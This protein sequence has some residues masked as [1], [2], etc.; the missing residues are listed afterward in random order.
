MLLKFSGGVVMIDEHDM[1]NSDLDLDVFVEKETDEPTSDDIPKEQRTLRTQAYD[2]SVSDLVRMM[3]DEDIVFSPEYQR[4]YIWDNKKASLLIESILLNI[5]IPVVY[6]SED[7]DSSWNIVDGLQRLN[8]LRR[9]CDNNYRLT[10]LEVLQELNGDRYEDL[11]Q[12]AKRVLNNGMIRI[13]LIFNDSHPEI[14][15]DIF[16]RL[17][18]GSVKLKEQELRNCLYRGS[19]NEL[20]K[21]LRNNKKFLGILG[22]KDPHKRMDDVELILRYFAFSKNYNHNEKVMTHYKGK[23]KSFLNIYMH[24]NQN[25]PNTAINELEEKFNSTIDKVFAVFGNKAFRR[26]SKSGEVDNSINRSIMDCIMVSFEN[27]PIDKLLKKKNDIIAMLKELP[28]QD[29]QFEEAIVIGTSDKKRV[30][31]RLSVWN[32]KLSEIL[33]NV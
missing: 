17:N 28:A 3:R 2:K 16:M 15:Y 1:Q 26:I 13:V 24:E 27:Y 29:E 25:I 20:L 11:N 19:L 33:E 31:Y 14:K 5:P 32:T 23:V 6:A 30:E 22:L 18:T 21:K 10:G 12:K 9:F 7:E 4:N 8:A